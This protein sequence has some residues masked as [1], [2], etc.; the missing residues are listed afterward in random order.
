MKA[1][2]VA[3]IAFFFIRLLMGEVPLF[4]GWLWLDVAAAVGL[5]TVLTVHTNAVLGVFKRR[6]K[7]LVAVPRFKGKPK[8]QLIS[9]EEVNL[10]RHYLRKS[11]YVQWMSRRSK[12]VLLWCA[13]WQLLAY[14]LLL[15]S[16]HLYILDAKTLITTPHIENHQFGWDI[17]S[18]VI[19]ISQ[20]VFPMIFCLRFAY[21]AARQQQQWKWHPIYI[22]DDIHLIERYQ[23]SALLPEE[24]RVDPH[25]PLDQIV[26]VWAEVGYWGGMMRGFGNVYFKRRL[27]ENKDD[28]KVYTLENMPRAELMATTLRDHPNCPAGRSDEVQ[29]KEVRAA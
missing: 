2:T 15:G 1:I 23:E 3:L 8:V 20:W 28:D 19:W 7:E 12:V 29:E 5:I 13:V 14:L 16:A 18:K 25:I 27:S 10:Q 6:K 24:G 17:P 11:E 9:N 26:E 4:D 21:L 22:I